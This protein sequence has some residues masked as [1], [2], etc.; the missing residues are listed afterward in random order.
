M[1]ELIIIFSSCDFFMYFTC[2]YRQVIIIIFT[3][4]QTYFHTQ[5][6][7][8]KKYIIIILASYH[9][10]LY[11]QFVLDLKYYFWPAFPMTRATVCRLPGLKYSRGATRRLAGR[12]EERHEYV[13]SNHPT[14][15]L[16]ETVAPGIRIE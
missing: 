7:T 12:K 2:L 14:I 6:L 10:K 9:C 1:N 8:L 13:A 11:E 16:S 15:S 5:Y 4:N 3:F